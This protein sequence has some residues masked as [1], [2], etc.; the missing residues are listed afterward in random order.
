MKDVRNLNDLIESHK[1]IHE[2]QVLRTLT[3]PFARLGLRVRIMMKPDR[4]HDVF[5]QLPVA[6]D[7]NR[8]IDMVHA[9]NF[10][11]G[12][13][14]IHER[15]FVWE[16]VISLPAARFRIIERQLPKIPQ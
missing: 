12:A 13:T 14:G 15:F 10:F 3:P 1:P 6:Q 11:L 8:D 5:R 9:E 2:L 4:F 7:A 16:C